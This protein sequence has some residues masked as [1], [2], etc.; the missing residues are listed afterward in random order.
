MSA[1]TNVTPMTA[2]AH[3]PA[4]TVPGA[5]LMHPV[6]LAAVVALG[7]N[8]HILKDAYPGF[9]T[10]KLSDVAGMVFFPAFLASAVEWSAWI[11]GRQVPRPAPLIAWCSSLTGIVFAAINLSVG[12]GLVY[13]GSVRSLWEFLALPPV[14]FRHVSDPSDLLALPFLLVPIAL[15][16][17]RRRWRDLAALPR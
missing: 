8:D 3:R 6:V 17:R 15:A 9:V 11:S 5:L 4:T 14:A 1:L 7:M 10:G 12:A 16:S 13:L 2:A